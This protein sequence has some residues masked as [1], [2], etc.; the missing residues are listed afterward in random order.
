MVTK[1]KQTGQLDQNGHSK[2]PGRRGGED[3]N[4]GAGE[5]RPG[6]G[7]FWPKDSAGQGFRRR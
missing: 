2:P 4:H 3:P 1:D 6:R 7:Q 5:D